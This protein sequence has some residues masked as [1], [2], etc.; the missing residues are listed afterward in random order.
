L[1]DLKKQNKLS[2]ME[3]ECKFTYPFLKMYTTVQRIADEYNIIPI[4]ERLPANKMEYVI[5]EIFK[6]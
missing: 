4:Q 5:K 2:E 1:L 6:L 3:V